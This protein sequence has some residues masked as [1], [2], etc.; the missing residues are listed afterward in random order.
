MTDTVK[1]K[2]FLLFLS[3]ALALLPL[4]AASPSRSFVSAQ[5]YEFPAN[6]FSLSYG[7]VSYPEIAF[8]IGGV[9]GAGLSFGTA[10]PSKMI[11]TGTI[12]LEYQ[13]FVHKIVAVGAA[14][15]YEH[16]IMRFDKAV[17]TDEDGNK[18]Y[19]EGETNH[20]DMVSIMPSLKLL[21]FNRPHFSMYSKLA[22]GL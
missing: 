6:E 14:C 4:Q 13:R 19:T 2:A 21:W 22:A 5:G 8:T 1:R 10:T 12:N 18:I 20:H 3:A 11:S 17:G 15:S 7:R 9:L 16:Y